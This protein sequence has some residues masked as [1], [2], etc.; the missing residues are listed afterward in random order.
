MAMLVPPSTNIVPRV[1]TIPDSRAYVTSKPFTRPI[2]QATTSAHTMAI[3]GPTSGI[4]K[5]VTIDDVV[6]V[7][8]TER[9]KLPPTTT[10]VSPIETRQLT[11]ME[12]RILLKFE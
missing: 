4:M 8:P 5:A 12:K 7:R 3:Q 1:T 6:T 11:I 9:S 2:A 10:K